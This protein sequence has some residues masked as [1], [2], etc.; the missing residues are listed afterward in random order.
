VLINCIDNANDND[1]NMKNQDKKINSISVFYNPGCEFK[2][3]NHKIKAIF[4]H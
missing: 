1:E 4:I 2:P 3:N